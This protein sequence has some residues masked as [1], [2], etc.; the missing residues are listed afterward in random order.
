MPATI[1]SLFSTRANSIQEILNKQ[2]E[3]IMPTADPVF[4]SMQMG[5]GNA[6][7]IGRDFLI[8]R[9][10][11]SGL[12]G[13]IRAGGSVQDFTL[14]G[15]PHNFAS[16]TANQVGAKLFK[17]GLTRTFPD[18]LTGMKQQTFRMSVPMRAMDTN[19]A[20]MLS[21]L[22]LEATAANIAEIVQPTLAAF[23]RHIALTVSNYFYLSQNDLYRLCRLTAG[24]WTLSDPG[25]GANRRLTID[26]K[27]DNYAIN[28]FA[29]GQQ[30]Q[31]ASQAGALRNG[32]AITIVESVDETRAVVTFRNV[33]DSVFNAGGAASVADNDIVIV[34]GTIGTSATPYASS[35]FFTGIAGVRSW[36]KT[37]QGGNDNIILGP[38]ATNESPFSGRI[39]VTVHPEF[40]SLLFDAGNQ[41]LTQQFLRRIMARWHS[42]RAVRY[43]Q[44]I[45]LLLASEGVWL[46]ME[47]TQATREIID[48]TGRLATVQN[49]QG[50]EGEGGMVFTYEGET[51]RGKTSGCMQANTVWG[52]KSKNNWDVY[53]PASF[54]GKSFDKAPPMVPFQFVGS[55]LNG[56]DSHQIP[57]QKVDANGNTALTEGVQMP[58]TFTMQVVPR[59]IPGIVIQN[60][61]EDRQYS[62]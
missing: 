59:Q 11:Q 47:A 18:P 41:P 17:Q 24:S 58:G 44:S 42:A 43:G 27:L 60:V 25:T 19:L 6:S 61:A 33:D 15:D 3:M 10:F 49:G 5:R 14:Y 8:H 9:T 45:D 20:M 46:A 35:P 4:K 50:S 31:I 22:R 21:E 32:S 28:R 7:A 13:V 51:Y 37:G 30:V 48:R 62:L 56:T 23:G 12:A 26:L 54:K 40:K 55:T 53:T 16:A 38:E 34:P 57:I 1:G 2:V 52:I 29:P 39:D 36:L